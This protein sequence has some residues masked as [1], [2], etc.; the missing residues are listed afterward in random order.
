MNSDKT[1]A[2]ILVVDDDVDFLAQQRLLLASAGFEVV[3][4]ESEK[5]AEEVLER[6]RPDVAVL[7]LMMEHTDGGFALCYHIKKRDPGIGVILVTG[8]ASE[9][10]LTFDA[11][12][13]EERS[14]I[15]ADVLLPKPIRQEQLLRAIARLLEEG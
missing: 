8:V 5:Q 6:L 9:T 14:W 10:S 11:A 2:T 15:K 3:T 12:T 1:R 7:D 4:A 13:D